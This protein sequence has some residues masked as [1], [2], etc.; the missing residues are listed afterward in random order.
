MAETVIDALPKE[1]KKGH[2]TKVTSSISV[3]ELL[4]DKQW[5]NNFF[6][7]MEPDLA[8][9]VEKTIKDAVKD[10][11]LPK[12]KI[13][14]VFDKLQQEAVGDSADLITTSI[15]TIKEDLKSILKENADKSADEIE[16]V[17]RAKYDD[18]PTAATIARQT[19]N[20]AQEAARTNTWKKS[21]VGF[22]RRW[23][24]QRD[25][26]V[27][28]PPESEYNHVAADGEVEDKPNGAGYF[29]K[30]GETLKAPRVGGSAGNTINCRCRTLPQRIH[31]FQ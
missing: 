21:G 18:Y 12:D 29:H 2:G 23:L 10:G 17:I 30:T 15:D 25:D 5:Y 13:E 11:D 14:S 1:K 8:V 4:S 3:D 19:S 24:S 20:V 9:L 31:N 28:Q 27:R 26:L 6:L 7:S 22:E 16:Q